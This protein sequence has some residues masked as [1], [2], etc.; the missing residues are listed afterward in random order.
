MHLEQSDTR[1]SARMAEWAPIFS[2][3]LCLSASL[4]NLSSAHAID[5][6]E[7]QVYTVET[8]EHKKWDLELHSNGVVNAVGRLAKD[9]LRPHEIH[10]TIEATYGL[11]PHVE[12]GQYFAMAKF[13]GGSFGY[14][15]SRT[16]LHFGIGDPDAW[17]IAFGGNFEIAYMR[18]QAD[19]NSL[20]LELRPI[21]Q[22]NF[23]KLSLVADF[24][25][26]KAMRGPGSHEGFGLLPSV[27]ISYELFPWMTPALEYYGDIGPIRNPLPT[28]LQQHFVVPAINLNLLPQLEFN[29]GVGIG[30]TQA[31]RGTFIKSIIGWTF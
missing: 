17:P 21:L 31:S 26:E 30:T 6:Y 9:E 15:G 25:F 7:I 12:I 29:F 20:S 22:K 4:I 8:T 5:L 2:V 19:P 27:M 11:F 1:R 13:V 14:A 3:I 28:K 10:E 23:G 16:K 24:A 18:Q